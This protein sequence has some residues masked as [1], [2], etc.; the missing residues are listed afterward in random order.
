MSQRDKVKMIFHQLTGVDVVKASIV[1]RGANQEPF[2][3]TKNMS[4]DGLNLARFF[5]RANKDEKPPSTIAVVY[6]K[7]E[8]LAEVKELLGETPIVKEDERD[9]VTGVYLTDSEVDPKDVL[10]LDDSTAV[11]VTGL[12]KSFDG[13][14]LESDF[15][16][17]LAT[18]QF[19]P[20]VRIATEAMGEALWNAMYTAEPGVPPVDT[21]NKILAD[22]SAYVSNLVTM[23]PV[24]AFKFEGLT[25]P[26]VETPVVAEKTERVNE[27]LIKSFEAHGATLME[28]LAAVNT[29][30]KAE[31]VA[32]FNETGALLKTEHDALKAEH[33]ALKAEHDALGESVKGI[34]VSAQSG[35]HVPKKKDEEERSLYDSALKFEGLEG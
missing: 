6:T 32:K 11:A 8:R 22:F 29:L 5:V 25:D 13:Y 1:N 31:D 17:A 4:K 35:D 7:T 14:T 20:S 21:V 30:A 33:D 34:T 18:G 2:R 16:A 3:K 27:A 10:K 26:V 9:G 15:G 23:V 24:E 19:Y 12:A 28:L